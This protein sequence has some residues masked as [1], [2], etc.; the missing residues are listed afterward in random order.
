M[1][2]QVAACSDARAS[3]L[4]CVE[5]YGRGMPI[6]SPMAFQHDTGP[7]DLIGDIHGCATELEALLE[8]LGYRVEY[9]GIEG[10]R[11]YAISHADRRKP[12]FLGD[13]VDRGPRSPDV[14]RLVMGLTKAG[15]AHTVAGNHDDKFRRWLDGRAVKITHGIEETIEQFEREDAAFRAEVR[16]F[17]HD[18]PTH[19]ILDDG[20]LLVAHAGLTEKFQGRYCGEER[21]F[22]LFGDVARERDQYGLAIR[23][24]W[25]ADY[26]GARHVVHGH[27]AEPDVRHENRVWCIDTGCVFGGHLTALRW[28]E[29]EIVQV[30]AEAAYFH[31][32]RWA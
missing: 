19:L 23:R 28:P 31:S 30:P 2:A 7:F 27:V 22:A 17:I 6:D 11:T 8:R 18:L 4:R 13:L 25:A 21:A 1:S 15:R 9:Q 3:A 16:E 20:N 26:S 5:G 10:S 24:N 32:P 14:L 12:V 29:Q